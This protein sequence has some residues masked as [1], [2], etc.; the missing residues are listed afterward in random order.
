MSQ[1]HQT[2]EIGLGVISILIGVA[3]ILGSRGLGAIPG[4]DYG[5]D[6]LPRVIAVFSI[7][8]GIAML[9]QAL[10]PRHMADSASAAEGDT[11]WMRN[12]NAWLRL[13]GGLALVIAYALFSPVT[14]FVIAGF[15]TVAGLALLMGVRPL[16]SV[17]LGIVAAFVLRYL[18]ADL[19]LVPLPRMS[20][21]GPGG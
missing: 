8:V 10:R 7:C 17:I 13:A 9:I 21:P 3:L 11:D 2:R 14:G 19:L 15:V 18:F 12:I 4:Q 5:A 20:L 1:R 16:Y 6:T